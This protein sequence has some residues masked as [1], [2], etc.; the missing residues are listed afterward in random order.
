M[1]IIWIEFPTG[2]SSL[3]SACEGEPKKIEGLVTRV[4]RDSYGPRSRKRPTLIGLYFQVDADYACALIDGLD[5]YVAMKAVFRAL[6]AE[7]ATKFL[8]TDKAQQAINRAKKMH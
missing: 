3:V 5:D 2:S 1:P 4:V 6:G 7:H 8:K